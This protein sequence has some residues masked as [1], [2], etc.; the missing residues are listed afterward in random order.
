MSWYRR[1][2]LADKVKEQNSALFLR[3]M[4]CKKFL[5]SSNGEFTEGGREDP[6]NWKSTEEMDP[7][8]LRDREIGIRENINYHSPIGISDGICPACMRQNIR[9]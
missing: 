8:E 2:K 9:I 6:D 4:Y 1:A 5:T 7:E 3:C